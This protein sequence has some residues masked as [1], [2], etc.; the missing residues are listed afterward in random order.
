M[1][2]WLSSTK[3]Q[4][5]KSGLFAYYFNYVLILSNK[6]V[7]DNNIVMMKQEVENLKENIK[8]KRINKK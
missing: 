4:D 2:I 8:N 6:D 5:I 7:I 3:T 1:Y